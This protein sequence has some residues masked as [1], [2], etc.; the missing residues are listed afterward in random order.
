VVLLHHRPST[1]TH[2][3]A[4]GHVLRRIEAAA[5]ASVDL[6]AAAAEAVRRCH[7]IT[8]VVRR[9]LGGH[10]GRRRHRGL[11]VGGIGGGGGDRVP[12]V[13]GAGEEVGLERGEGLGDVEHHAHVEVAPL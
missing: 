3:I 4:L 5:A 9:R 7:V 1:D 8:V 2:A 6:T 13:L 10:G 12:L 11:V